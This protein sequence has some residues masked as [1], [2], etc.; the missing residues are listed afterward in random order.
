MTLFFL[1]TLSNI[2]ENILD[3]F[4]PDT[5]LEFAAMG[6]YELTTIHLQ[7]LKGMQSSKQGIR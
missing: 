6:Y 7:Q 4:W 5:P 3:K 2:S 1:A